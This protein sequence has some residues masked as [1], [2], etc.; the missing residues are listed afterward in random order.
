MDQLPVQIKV[1]TVIPKFYAQ[2]CPVCHGF[3]TL[4]FGTKVCQG[5]EGR[6]FVF[7]PTGIDGEDYGRRQ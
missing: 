1:Q 3:G 2:T 6:G 4:K 7:V 5:C